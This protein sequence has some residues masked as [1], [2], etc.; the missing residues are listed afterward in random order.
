MRYYKLFYLALVCVV[1]S[2]AACE[3]DESMEDCGFDLPTILLTS[4]SECTPVVFQYNDLATR[5]AATS[6]SLPLD[7]P[8]DNDLGRTAELALPGS[9][10]MDL[11][12][13]S[14]IRTDL[15]VQVFGATDC[16]MDIQPVTSCISISEVARVLNLSGL[17]AYDQL[18][19]HF[20]FADAS[21]LET[22]DF[23]SFALYEQSPRGVDVDYGGLGQ[24]GEITRNCD[25]LSWQRVIL[26]NCDPGADIDAWAAET[27]LVDSERYG[28][29]GGTIIAQDV[30]AGLDPNVVGPAVSRR[31]LN[32]ND[33]DFIVEADHIIYAPSGGGGPG[34]LP[35]IDGIIDQVPSSLVACL[36]F[37]LNSDGGSTEDEDG[38]I[39]VTMID[40]G[41][42][43]GGNWDGIWDNHINQRFSDNFVRPFQL[44]FDFFYGTTVPSDNLGHGTN[45]AGAL[46]GN[47]EGFQ[48]LTVIHHKVFG[49]DGQSTYFGALVAIYSAVELQSDIINCS[50]GY[51][52]IV[53]PRGMQCAVDYAISSGAVFIAS[54]GNSTNN[55]SQAA[56]PQWPA[57]FSENLDERFI[58]VTSFQYQGSPNPDLPILCPTFSNFQ[59]PFAGTVDV[60][61]YLTTETPAY[62]EGFFNYKAGTSISAPLV[63]SKVATAIAELGGLSGYYG[64][65]RESPLFNDQVQENFFQTVCPDGSF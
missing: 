62:G 20:T 40:S 31:R 38:Q 21:T 48:P 5:P 60:A 12:V 58:S 45:T 36:E 49:I 19:L 27:G 50:W 17:S 55:I 23:V 63:A 3:D 18:Y 57:S 51:E 54:A 6:L 43:I 13:Y 2:W 8:Q 24:V 39:V 33:D 56:L 32:R 53:L 28:G 22:D 46:I 42:E 59:T 10:S 9:P 52:D 64:E 44:G 47:Y 1:L 14:G 4:N 25:G 15:L 30:P 41:V 29:N 26:T 7:C 35:S 65:L 34:V 37:D 11:H 16:D 61:A